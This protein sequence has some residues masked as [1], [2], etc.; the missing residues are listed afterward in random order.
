MTRKVLFCG[1][2]ITVAETGQNHQTHPYQF[3]WH[4]DAGRSAPAAQG[5]ADTEAEARK[6]AATAARAALSIS[7]R[8]LN[9]LEAGQ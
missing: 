3:F 2:V 8:E 6:R 1:M 5:Y 4:V 9:E 7:A